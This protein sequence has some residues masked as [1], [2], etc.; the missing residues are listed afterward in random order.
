MQGFL[1]LAAPSAR[2]LSDPDFSSAAAALEAAG[3]TVGDRRWLCNGRAGDIAFET[4]NGLPAV[5]TPDGVDGAVVPADQRR[6]RV[7]IA[8]MDSTMIEIETLDTLAAELGFGEEVIEITNRSMN[9]ELD[10][11]DSLRERVAMLAD[12]PADVAMKTVMDRVTYTPG[13]AQAVKTMR[14]HGAYC[15]LVSGGFTFTTERVH[16]VLGFNEHRANV[17]ETSDGR[18]AGTVK[19]PVLSRA[20]KLETLQELCARQG[21]GLDAAC[22]VGD[23]ANDLD[24]LMAAG[25]G[26]AYY[27]KPV[28]RRQARYRIDHTDLTSLLYFQGYHRDEFAP[29]D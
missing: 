21:I 11:A 6:K 9:G 17:L 3:A 15:A 10:F 2:P 25:L 29:V 18:L 13:G 1:T 24:M 16:A 7:L 19:E 28:V 22:T 23:G 12:L 8:D 27:G 14:A 26:V 5:D 4:A 20:S